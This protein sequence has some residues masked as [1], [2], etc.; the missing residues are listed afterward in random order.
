M[1]V[2]VII[3]ID[4]GRITN[5]EIISEDVFG[6]TCMRVRFDIATPIGNF[7]FD[8]DTQ[9]VGAIRRLLSD[10]G[11]SNI[12]DGTHS[13]LPMVSLDIGMHRDGVVN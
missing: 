6:Q 13:E 8:S 12:L 3:K 10:L 7:S 1:E 5:F 4:R 2:V 9:S 11:Y